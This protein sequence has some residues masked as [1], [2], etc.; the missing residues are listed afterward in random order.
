MAAKETRT[1]YLQPLRGDREPDSF[2]NN[3]IQTHLTHSNLYSCK[4]EILALTNYRAK[5]SLK[6]FLQKPLLLTF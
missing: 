5:E 2:I 1:F 4:L 6:P 3:K